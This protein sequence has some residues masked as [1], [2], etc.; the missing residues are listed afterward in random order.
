MAKARKNVRK[1]CFWAVIVLVLIVQT[2]PLVWV[3]LSSLKTPEEFRTGSVLALPHSLNFENFV[4]AVSKSHIGTYFLNS[5]LIT[6]ASVALIVLLS[7]MAGFVLEKMTFKIN[8][9]IY[10]FFVAGIMVPIQVTLIPMFMMYSR[11]KLLN[12]YIGI[13]LPQV[14]FALPVAVMLFTGFYKFL[15]DEI[16]EAGIIDGCSTLQIFGR[17]VVPMSVNTIVTIVIMNG[18]SCWNEF[19]FSFTFLSKKDMLTV[20]L[21]L[22]D[23]VG[24]FGF[25]DWNASFAA[26]TLTTLPTLLV[27]FMFSKQVIKG[28]TAGAVKA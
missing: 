11:L 13:I 24:K 15:P 28:M 6:V 14:G 9:M 10:I 26:I 19:V 22:R 5:T 17:I 16:I 18:V 8:K 25:V 7:A 27:Y 3:M 2:Y 23:F 21:G 1:I 4:S 12:T 20:T